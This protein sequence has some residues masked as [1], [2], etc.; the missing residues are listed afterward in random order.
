M[1]LLKSGYNKNL[2]QDGILRPLLFT[3]YI[4]DLTDVLH[5]SYAMYADNTTIYIHFS[6]IIIDPAGQLSSL[7]LGS[8]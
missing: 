4:N 5:S 1:G 3:V 8:L 6:L 2:P 7:N